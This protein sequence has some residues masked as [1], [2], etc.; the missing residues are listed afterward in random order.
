MNYSDSDI[1]EDEDSVT[2]ENQGSIIEEDYSMD[3]EY[4]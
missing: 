3:I 2:N 4:Y 1:N